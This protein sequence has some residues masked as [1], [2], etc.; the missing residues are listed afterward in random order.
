MSSLDS[1]PASPFRLFTANRYN[2]IKDRIVP[3][4]DNQAFWKWLY[5]NNAAHYLFMFCG[6]TLFAPMMNTAGGLAEWIAALKT[7]KSHKFEYE[8]ALKPQASKNRA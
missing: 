6:A 8:V 1:S 4:P 2:G 5:S 3:V 7:A